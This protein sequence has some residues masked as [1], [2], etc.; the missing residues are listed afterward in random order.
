MNPKI[1]LTHVGERIIAGVGEM[2]DENGNGL[3][4]VLRCP[5]ILSMIPAGETSPDGV[6]TQFNVNFT[7]WIPYSMDNQFKVPYSSVVAI[8]DVDPN[9]LEIYLSRFAEI[10]N[11]DDT[12]STSDSSDSSEGSGVSDSGD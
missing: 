2:K 6:A 12:V 11:D 5:Y 3:C 8:G 9:I 7:K 1:I 4:L 10:L